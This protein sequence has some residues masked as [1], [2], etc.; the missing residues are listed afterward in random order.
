MPANQIAAVQV[1]RDAEVRQSPN[2]VRFATFGETGVAALDLNRM[3]EAVPTAI[4]AALEANTYFFVPATLR[5]DAAKSSV[6]VATAWSDEI[7]DAAICHRNVEL[8]SGR[9]GVFISARLLSDSFALSFEFF[10]NVAHAF[11]D[12]A[13]VPAGFGELVWKQAVDNLR[14][15]TSLDAWESR[16]LAF[17][18]AHNYSPDEPAPR[19]TRAYSNSAQPTRALNAAAEP[20]AFDEKERNSYITAAFTDSVAV[21]LLSLA[22]DFNYSD[23]RERDYPLLAPAALAARLRL[24]AELFPPNPNYE[25][26]VK[27]RRKA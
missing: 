27:Y 7:S 5:E 17:G 9:Q 19:R 6:M 21:Y 20:T 4:V 2:G 1:A 3:L 8:G 23:L 10:I 13:G 12:K 11:V 14:G 16:N 15:E 25:F 22:M 24:I 26:A 18:R